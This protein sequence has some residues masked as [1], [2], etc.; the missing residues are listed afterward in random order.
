MKF[1][2]QKKAPTPRI[3]RIALIGID[4]DTTRLLAQWLSDRLED[5]NLGVLCG[6]DEL[7]AQ[8]PVEEIDIVIDASYKQYELAEACAVVAEMALLN[9]PC[10]ALAHLNKPGHHALLHAH[11]IVDVRPGELTQQQRDDLAMDKAFLCPQA[12]YVRHTAQGDLM[13]ELSTALDQVIQSNQ[14]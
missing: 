6:D 5:G 12:C 13:H 7:P 3:L 14:K 1:G 2:K 8:A 11:L 10:H 4:I 9:A